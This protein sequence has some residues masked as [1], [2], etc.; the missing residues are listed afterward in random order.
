[1]DAIRWIAVITRPRLRLTLAG[2]TVIAALTV[3]TIGLPS[4]AAGRQPMVAVRPGPRLTPLARGVSGYTSDEQRY[5][6]FQQGR[7]VTVI[8][9]ASGR[10]H[11]TR[12]PG[13]CAMSLGAG[14]GNLVFPQL[15]VTCSTTTDQFDLLDVRNGSLIRLPAGQIWTAIGRSWAQGEFPKPCPDGGGTC[16]VFYEWRTQ[17]T[18]YLPLSELDPAAHPHQEIDPD[19]DS[20]ALTLARPC[21]PFEDQSRT[22]DVDTYAPPYLL[23]GAGVAPIFSANEHGE[24]QL[25]RC[26]SDRTVTL[27]QGNALDYELSAGNVSWSDGESSYDHEIAT[28]RTYVWPGPAEPHFLAADASTTMHTGEEILVAR[29]PAPTCA[30]DCDT[31]HADLFVAALP[32]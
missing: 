19:L 21:A 1:M 8:D 11:A 28:R 31:T 9:T 13:K 2:S 29:P 5:V 32:H 6:A 14:A 4:R 10:R 3:L 16:R 25:G 30:N 24:F 27:M 17:A 26:G 7:K 23:V 12:A 18:R 15:L 20:A 22:N